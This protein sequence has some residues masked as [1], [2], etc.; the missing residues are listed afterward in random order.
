[1]STFIDAMRTENTLTENGM[2]TSSSSTNAC[3]DLFFIMGAVRFQ[4]RTDEGR[5]RLIAKFEAAYNENPLITRKLMFWGR[6][7]R[8]GAG[9]REAFRVLLRYASEVYPNDVIDNIHLISEFGRWDDLFV[10]FGTKVEDSAIQLIIKNLNDGNPLLAKWIPRTG[11]KIPQDKKAIANKIRS[12]MGLSPKD[13]RKQ[14]VSLT[15]VIETNL[16]NKDFGNVNYAHVP[17]VAMARY[18]KAFG[19]HDFDSFEAYKEALANGETKVNAGAV[20]PYDVTKTMD[21]GDAILANEQWKAL[22]NYMEDS[23]EYVLPICDVSGSMMTTISG[24]TSALDVCISLGLYI[25]ERNE[26]P[27]K[28]AFVTF[29]EKPSLEYLTGDLRSRLTQL[30]QSNWGMSTNLEATFN[31]VLDQAIKHNVSVDQ[32]PTC[33]LI[34]SDMEFNEA[35]RIS[36]NAITMIT[37]KYEDSGYK[38]PKIVFWNLVSRHDNIPVKATANGTALIS[39]FSPS[40]LKAVLSGDSM[41]PLS[42]M[43]KTIDTER[44]SVIQ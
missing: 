26:G 30:T 25:S 22:P 18:S 27:F 21:N 31:M 9:E 20:Y 5:E 13:F 32:M 41:S 33:I 42:I 19:K 37:R 24:T 17:S 36:D 8:G 23:A 28:D 10:T 4:L 16:C 35:T 1:M 7:I 3:V 2:V 44:Y 11:G 6:D 38:M 43:I 40:I 14:L 34:M 15:N 29:S 12:K 39:G